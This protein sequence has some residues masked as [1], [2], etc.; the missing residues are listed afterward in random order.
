MVK[1]KD[2]KDGWIYN[3]VVVGCCVCKDIM[4]KKYMIMI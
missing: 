3:N 2:V 4:K 1:V